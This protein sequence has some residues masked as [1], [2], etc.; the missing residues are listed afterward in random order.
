MHNESTLQ[1]ACLKTRFN[2]IMGTPHVQRHTDIPLDKKT[3]SSYQMIVMEPGKP[4]NHNLMTID[5]SPLPFTV[6]AA[7]V[8]AKHGGNPEEILIHKLLL[9]DI[10]T[11]S[12]NQQSQRH[13][14]H[15]KSD[16][17][18]WDLSWNRILNM[19]LT[20]SHSPNVIP[21]QLHTSKSNNGKVASVKQN[22][23]ND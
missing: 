21:G 19:L 8:T 10:N 7:K 9:M 5:D 14:Q 6:T 16:T 11:T 2:I 22:Y 4:Q 15:Y 23:P 17:Q 3:P 13:S 20:L 12:M 1:C 18:L